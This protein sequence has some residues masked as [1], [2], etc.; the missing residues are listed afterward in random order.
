MMAG[1]VRESLPEDSGSAL[2]KKCFLCCLYGQEQ[3]NRSKRVARV[4]AI[5]GRAV[6]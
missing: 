6:E 2:N 4:V 5:K 1:H 3:K